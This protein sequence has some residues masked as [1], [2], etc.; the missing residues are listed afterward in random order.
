MFILTCK[1]AIC[2][3]LK[4]LTLQKHRYVYKCYNMLK[5]LDS[6]GHTYWVTHLR[7]N[8]MSNGFS[9]VWNAQYVVN[10][11][12]FLSEYVQKLKDQYIQIWTSKCLNSPKLISYSK[13]KT[14][15]ESESYVNY[16][17]LRKYRNVYSCLRCSAHSIEIELGRYQNVN[18]NGR[19]VHIVKQL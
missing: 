1:R 18:R 3:W 19:M 12:S 16:L 11:K 5:S 10:E 7:K 4:L 6:V 15:F 13:Y 8:L 17:L 9:Y 14:S 2:Y